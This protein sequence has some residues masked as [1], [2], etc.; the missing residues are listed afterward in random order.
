MN[1]IIA[2]R[3]GNTVEELNEK[4]S[5]TERVQWYAHLVLEAEYAEKMAKQAKGGR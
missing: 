5:R 2:E 1:F 3:T 4:L